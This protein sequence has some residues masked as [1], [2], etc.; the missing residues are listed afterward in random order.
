MNANQ[1][2]INPTIAASMAGRNNSSS[3]SGNSSVAAIPR[4]STASSQTTT[5]MITGADRTSEDVVLPLTLRGR[6][7]VTWYVDRK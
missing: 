5:M 1:N 4:E 7:T 3:L 6:P 2:D